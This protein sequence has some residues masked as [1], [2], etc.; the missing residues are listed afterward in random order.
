VNFMRA[1]RW[2]RLN[3]GIVNANKVVELRNVAEN[4]SAIPSDQ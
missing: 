1:I 2:S 3:E 4:S